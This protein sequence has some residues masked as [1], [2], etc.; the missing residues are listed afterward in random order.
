MDFIIPKGSDVREVLR[1]NGIHYGDLFYMTYKSNP[2]KR[3]GIVDTTN[4]NLKRFNFENQ[5][6][7]WSY[8][9][10]QDFRGFAPATWNS[11][12][13][14]AAMVGGDFYFDAPDYKSDPFLMQRVTTLIMDGAVDFHVIKRATATFGTKLV[15]FIFGLFIMKSQMGCDISPYPCEDDAW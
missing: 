5:E 15:Q 12:D 11:S 4:Q 14:R 10:E 13:D 7:K 2:D 9:H 3:V 1:Q 8:I 6:T